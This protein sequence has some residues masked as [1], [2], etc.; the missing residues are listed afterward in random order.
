MPPKISLIG[1]G[2]VVFA[3]R[4]LQDVACTPSLKDSHISLMD[5][6][7]D[8]L[9]L[10]G[11]FASKLFAEVGSDARI[12]TTANR[13]ESLADTDYVLTTIQGRRHELNEISISL[14]STGSIR[15][16]EIRLGPGVYSR[17]C[18]RCLF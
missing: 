2:S 9:R 18:G 10:I 17:R 16:S 5:I 11:D 6:D 1:A 3:R 7:E 4:L 8:R 15:R 13:R 14:G 12:E